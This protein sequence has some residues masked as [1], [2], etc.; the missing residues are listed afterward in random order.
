MAA[1]VTILDYVMPIIDRCA[2]LKPLEYPEA[3]S[4]ANS[5]TSYFPNSRWRRSA[6]FDRNISIFDWCCDLD[7]ANVHTNYEDNP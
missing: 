6:I 4:E 7:L 5:E 1:V 2:I 3:K